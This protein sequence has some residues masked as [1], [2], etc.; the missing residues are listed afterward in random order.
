MA[1]LKNEELT[2]KEMQALEAEELLKRTLLGGIARDEGQYHF[3][4][5]STAC[6][7]HTHAERYR[8]IL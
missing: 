6:V 5:C 4:S 7:G 1:S 3:I 8:G 2:R